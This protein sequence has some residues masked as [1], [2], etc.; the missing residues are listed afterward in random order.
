MR[1]FVHNKSLQK[2]LDENFQMVNSIPNLYNIILFYIERYHAFCFPGDVGQTG[3]QGLKGTVGATGN[4][5]VQGIKGSEGVQGLTG[6]VGATGSTG[7]TGPQG[8]VGAKGKCYLYKTML[9]LIKENINQYFRY[10]MHKECHLLY[11]SVIYTG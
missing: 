1:S 7:S 6:E 2:R 5:G 10:H 9:S 3:D 8:A 4:S 11:S